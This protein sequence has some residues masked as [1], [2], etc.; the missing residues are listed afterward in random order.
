M[1]PVIIHNDDTTPF[2]IAIQ[3][4]TEIFEYSK[5]D[6]IELADKIHN[7]GKVVLREYIYE[8]AETKVAEVERLNNAYDLDLRVTLDTSAE[9][10][11]MLALEE[12]ADEFLRELLIQ[13]EEVEPDSEHSELADR[14]TKQIN[15]LIDNNLGDDTNSDEDETK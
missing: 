15:E 8:I 11:K 5:D 12:E 7:E 9:K 1:Y 10:A 4:L 14:L 2:S 3:V 13:L 6:A